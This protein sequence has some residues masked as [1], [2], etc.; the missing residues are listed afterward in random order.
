M[1]AAAPQCKPW[2]RNPYLP[3][4]T[5]CVTWVELLDLSVLTF[6]AY[7]TEVILP[8]LQVCGKD[9]QKHHVRVL[10]CQGSGNDELFLPGRF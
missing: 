3:S 1:K 6:S 4:L 10:S 9:G 8:T 2:V 7:D 5:S